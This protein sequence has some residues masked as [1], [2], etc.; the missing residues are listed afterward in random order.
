MVPS[1]ALHPTHAAPG[2]PREFDADAAL[3]AALDMFW[4]QGYEATSLDD[5][6]RAMGISRSSFY[7]CFGSKHALLVAAIRRYSDERFEALA[8]IASGEADPATALRAVLTALTNPNGG[9]EGCFL[10]NCAAE[11]APHDPEVEAISRRHLERLEDLIA[12]LA[13]RR[14]V[15]P[16][17]APARARA[18]LS[19]GLGATMLRK[20]GTPSDRIEALLA[21]AEPLLA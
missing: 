17:A 16:G 7:G 9:R 19:L 15:P 11:L 2:R 13:A 20:A 3:V 10:V 14:G 8:A 6:T 12:G 21:E 5:L 1:P 18:L 4:R